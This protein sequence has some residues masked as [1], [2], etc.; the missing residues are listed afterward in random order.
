LWAELEMDTDRATSQADSAAL[1]VR[2]VAERGALRELVLARTHP[3]P[4]QLCVDAAA[5]ALL[6]RDFAVS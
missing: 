3:H 6:Q 4:R 1:R 2:Y 5:V